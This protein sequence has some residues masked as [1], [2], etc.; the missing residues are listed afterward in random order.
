[1]RIR[2]RACK[3]EILLSVTKNEYGYICLEPTKI[4]NRL[5]YEIF[6]PKGHG[7]QDEAIH[8]MELGEGL[9]QNELGNLITI[10]DRDLNKRRG[11]ANEFGKE[12]KKELNRIRK[13]LIKDKELLNQEKG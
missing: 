12:L 7:G 11:K 10:I 6:D 9:T 8:L 1:M 5:E 13:F 2:K 4:L 3:P